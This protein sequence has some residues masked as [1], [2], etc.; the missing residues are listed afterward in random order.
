[1]EDDD[2]TK[3]NGFEETNMN[4]T[5]IGV[6]LAR[7]L[8][9]SEEED[10]TLGNLKTP[11]LSRLLK[12]EETMD[13]TTLMPRSSREKYHR[14]DSD[15]GFENL[16]NITASI[17]SLNSLVSRDENLTESISLVTEAGSSVLNIYPKIL[18]D[19]TSGVAD[20]LVS[21]ILTKSPGK[22][23]TNSPF[24]R[25]IQSPSRN[26][27]IFQLSPSL[28]P[29]ETDNVTASVPSLGSLIESD[30]TSTDYFI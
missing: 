22:S 29:M 28:S 3:G 23:V 19:N 8:R 30:D 15:A 2:I 1:M 11:S 14:R 4:I 16:Q 17:P 5:R 25:D 27:E 7:L 6:S 18:D 10:M 24:R 26:D 12:Q 20:R 13:I 9:D 21:K